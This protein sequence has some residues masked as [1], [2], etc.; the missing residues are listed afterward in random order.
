MKEMIDNLI[1]ILNEEAK[2]YEDILKISKNKTDVIVKGKVSE[3]ENITNIEQ[4]L[5][6]KMGKLE[7]MRESLIIE[8][9]KQLGI[10]N[11]QMN[12]SKIS[13]YLDNDQAQRLKAFND[14]ITST[15]KELRDSNE[16][17]SRLIKNSLEYINFSINVLSS[18]DTGENNYGHSGVVSEGKKK[19]FF[20]VKL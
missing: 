2:I 4:S 1:K 3:L 11:D 14:K 19:N 15:V 9:A 16:L 5:V 8:L 12:V 13:K 17:N 7:N 6:F 18:A 20:D 10:S